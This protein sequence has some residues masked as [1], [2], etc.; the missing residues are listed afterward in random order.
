MAKSILDPN[1]SYN[2][3]DYFFLSSTTEETVAE[4]GYRFVVQKLDLP[5]ASLENVSL[6]K[7]K[8]DYYKKLPYFKRY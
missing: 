1:R 4:F 5:K 2:F 3:S 6:K 8:N 7:L